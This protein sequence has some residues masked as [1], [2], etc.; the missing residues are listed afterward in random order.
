MLCSE[1]NRQRI[2][3]IEPARKTP[4]FR[5]DSYPHFTNGFC[6][7]ASQAKQY[8]RASDK[9]CNPDPLYKLPKK[10]VGKNQ[11]FRHGDRRAVPFWGVMGWVLF[12]S[13]QRVCYTVKYEPEESL[14]VSLLSK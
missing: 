8:G 14:Q 4:A 3:I 11:A 6:E 12:D 5:P 13:L 9:L 7:S 1:S 10:D 2:S